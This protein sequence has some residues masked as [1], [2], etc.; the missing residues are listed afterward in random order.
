MLAS[1]NA[2]TGGSGVG[3]GGGID[4]GTLYF[5][6]APNWFPHGIA[7]AVYAFD[8]YNGTWLNKETFGDDLDEAN[9]FHHT[10]VSNDPGYFPVSGTDECW[11]GPG[12]SDCATHP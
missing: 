12:Y 6:P 11:D 2:T 7:T 10:W 3:G 4:A 9:N 5:L 1:K 8:L